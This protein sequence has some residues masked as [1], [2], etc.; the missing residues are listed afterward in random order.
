MSTSN[1]KWGEVLI[2]RLHVLKSAALKAVKYLWVRKYLAFVLLSGFLLW[3]T[4]FSGDGNVVKLDDRLRLLQ[5]QTSYSSRVSDFFGDQG[6]SLAGN[7]DKTVWSSTINGYGNAVELMRGEAPKGLLLTVKLDSVGYKNGFRDNDVVKR[8]YLT[9]D[10]DSEIGDVRLNWRSIYK[11]GA[12]VTVS[13]DSGDKVL[14]IPRGGDEGIS[15]MNVRSDK[16][17]NI[18]TSMH[19]SQGTSG[20]LAFSLYHLEKLGRGSI[21]SNDIVAATG[22]IY[23][24]NGIIGS[25]EGIE[26]KA[27]AAYRSG[28]TVLFVPKGQSNRVKH[29][30]GLSTYEV[31]SLGEAVSILCLRGAEDEACAVLKK[32]R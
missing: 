12:I 13:R 7:N 30:E 21:F 10:C 23:P 26:A 19:S 5:V 15:I 18:P 14:Q 6:F 16:F 27:E 22:S 11:C 9:G 25:V 3:P 31:S 20:G 32:R 29:Y 28:A 24:S 1:L 2:L 4:G 8:V 17:F